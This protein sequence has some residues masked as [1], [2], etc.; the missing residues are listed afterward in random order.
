[1]KSVYSSKPAAYQGSSHRSA[2]F[3]I[4]HRFDKEVDKSTGFEKHSLNLRLRLASAA[5][6]SLWSAGSPFPLRSAGPQWPAVGEE[7]EDVRAVAARAS[8]TRS[9]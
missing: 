1:M 6:S 4:L 2:V 3:S 7:E 8:L 5:R 9:L